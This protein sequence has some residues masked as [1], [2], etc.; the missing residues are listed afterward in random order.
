MKMKAT[1]RGAFPLAIAKQREWHYEIWKYCQNISRVQ[2]KVLQN[3][4][5]YG[6]RWA[7]RADTRLH[8]AQ[9]VHHRRDDAGAHVAGQG[10]RRKGLATGADAVHPKLQQSHVAGT[11]PGKASSKLGHS[12]KAT[13]GAL[14]G[15]VSI[16]WALRP[17]ACSHLAL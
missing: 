10:Q 12:A 7:R 3:L 17:S 13:L 1:D 16:R 4:R 15:Q 2:A 11:R 14:M 6:C 5:V 9:F 8:L